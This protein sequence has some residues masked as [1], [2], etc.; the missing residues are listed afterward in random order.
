MQC[1]GFSDAGRFRDDSAD[2]H[3]HGRNRRERIRRYRKRWWNRYVRVRVHPVR[4]FGSNSVCH[5]RGVRFPQ[6]HGK[7]HGA[8]VRATQTGH[9]CRTGPKV[10]RHGQLGTDHL[11]VGTYTVTE[12][13][14]EQKAKVKKQGKNSG[15]RWKH[16]IVTEQLICIIQLLRDKTDIFIWRSLFNELTIQF[17]KVDTDSKY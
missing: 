3:A 8:S 7:F 11:P 9:V 5:R 14:G 17:Y 15:L 2:V 12:Y 16:T 1:I 6:G 4:V 10:G 13:Q